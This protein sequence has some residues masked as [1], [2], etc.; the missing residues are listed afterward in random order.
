MG[1]MP[2]SWQVLRR[3]LPLHFTRLTAYKKTML[4]LFIPSLGLLLALFG[5]ENPTQLAGPEAPVPA[6]KLVDGAPAVFTATHQGREVFNITAT[7]WRDG[8]R[9][10]VSI[11]YDAPWGI[12]PVFSLATDAAIARGLSMDVEIVSD[13]L[14]HFKRIAITQ[15]MRTEL[16]P[17]GVGFFGHGHSHI[18]HDALGYH[19]AYQSFRTN[20]SLM[21]AWG[22]NPKVYA[23]PLFA[24]RDAQTQAANRQAGFIAARG[25]TR[26][27]SAYYIC[28][29]GVR[30]PEQWH[31]LPSVIMGN[32]STR[33]PST[34]DQLQPILIQT[35]QRRAW[36]IMT[37]HAIGHPEG[38]GY[39]PYVEFVRDLDFI[40]ANDFWSGNL[41]SVAAYIQERN[42]LDIQ[43]ARFFGSQM[44]NSFELF[45]GD[46]L[47]NDVY[48]EPLTLD[49]QFN[50][51]LGV[52]AARITPTPV[53]G[54]ERFIV[55]EN[56]LRLNMVPDE[57]LYTLS[58]ER[59]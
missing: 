37:Y 3:S 4:R 38:W 21:R 51:D 8:H 57:R 1:Q 55:E 40:R 53:A 41:A 42:A 14:S 50:P 56:H 20:F 17:R 22:L 47:D 46:G 5:C 59:E 6:G 33:D 12:H 45:I 34:H 29:D 36:T 25:G 28:A 15:R 24:G 32:A 35:L 10:A 26:D 16:M 44:P 31:N 52:R 13:K 23:Y 39:Y 11:T 7:K 49:F 30:E 58:L 19:A 9:A 48:D 18:D 43:I 2:R 54:Q 27:P